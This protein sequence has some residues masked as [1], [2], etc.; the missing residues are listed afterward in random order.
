MKF[1]N[2]IK[3]IIAAVLAILIVFSMLLSIALMGFIQ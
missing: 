1:N 3:R 2:K